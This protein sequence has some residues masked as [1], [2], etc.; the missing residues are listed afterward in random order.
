M[1][2]HTLMPREVDSVMA[3]VNREVY[4]IITHG[5]EY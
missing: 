3:F 4:K 5:R 1:V 2:S